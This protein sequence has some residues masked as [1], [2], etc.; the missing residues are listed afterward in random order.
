MVHR[1]NVFLLCFFIAYAPTQVFAAFSTTRFLDTIQNVRK[2]TGGAVADFRYKDALGKGYSALN[3]TVSSQQLAAVARK[4]IL[5][6]T[7]VTMIA[8]GV[9][10]SALIDYLEEDGW[11]VDVA[12]DRIYKEEVGE[13]WMNT[14]DGSG[15]T[16]RYD[17]AANACKASPL[18]TNWSF[19]H[20][21]PDTDPKRA[22]CIVLNPSNQ[23]VLNQ[24]VT[25]VATAPIQR[26][27]TDDEI[28]QAIDEG[29]EVPDLRGLI[30][31]AADEP[32]HPSNPFADQAKEDDPANCPA[33]QKFDS[34]SGEC[35]KDVATTQTDPEDP[36]KTTTEWPT[37]CNWA[38]TVCEYI[39]YVKPKVDTITKNTD[40]IKTATQKTADEQ[41]KARKELEKQTVN[42]KDFQDWAKAEPPAVPAEPVD[43]TYTPSST[44]AEFDVQYVQFS[45]MCPGDR[46]TSISMGGESVELTFSFEPLCDI[47]QKVRP[48]V[49]AAASISSFFIISGIRGSD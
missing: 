10:V 42:D 41:E 44:P 46:S 36:T 38:K 9:G 24:Y 31:P 20:A 32:D 15:G 22:K 18:P 14:Y 28:A 8:C 16:K 2:I 29:V 11:T 30:T 1:I 23:T 3:K 40:D 33:G 7:L 43:T 34:A 47:A 45:G 35:K 4:R 13:I 12:N 5:C 27:I 21:E 26:E 25:K 49:L 17:S 37:F 39:G 48:F 19:S 6:G